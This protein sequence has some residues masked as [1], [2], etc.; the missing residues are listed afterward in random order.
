MFRGGGGGRVWLALK[1][2][3]QETAHFGV[4]IPV[5]HHTSFRI[6]W[7]LVVPGDREGVKSGLSSKVALGGVALGGGGALAFS[8]A[9][10]GCA[11]VSLQNQ[12][13][14]DLKVQTE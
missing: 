10:V 14:L 13:D 12:R 3:Q 7:D 2:G 8:H 6:C 4:Q 11:G 9:F 5:Y 1:E